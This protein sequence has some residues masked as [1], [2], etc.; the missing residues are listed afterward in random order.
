MPLW[1]RLHGDQIRIEPVRNW[2][3]KPCVYVGPGGSGTDRIYSLVPYGST[4]EGDPIWNRTVP[5]LNQVLCK[6]CTPTIVDPIPNGS[7]HIRSRV[8]K[9]SLKS[10]IFRLLH[11]LISQHHN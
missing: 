1:Q 10:E 4:H 8:L 3:H 9:H 2:H 6:Q 11:H 5:V 7:G